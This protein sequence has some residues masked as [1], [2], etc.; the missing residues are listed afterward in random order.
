M[1]Y[2]LLRHLKDQSNE[3]GINLKIIKDTIAK[4]QQIVPEPKGLKIA[5]NK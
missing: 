2:K 5:Q 3:R 1:K 4:P